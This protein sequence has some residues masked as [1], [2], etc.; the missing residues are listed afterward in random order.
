MG[1]ASNSG[2][3]IHLA[4]VHALYLLRELYGD[5]FIPEEVKVEVVE[6]GKSK[7][8]ADALMVEEAIR[9]GWIK[10]VA[11]E[12]LHRILEVARVAGV[13]DA[14]AKVIWYAYE[15]DLLVLL[16]DEPAREFARSLGLKVRGTLGV[17]LESV[18]RGILERRRALE[19]LD[20]VAQIMYLSADV[21]NAVKREIEGISENDA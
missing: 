13:H 2:P 19:L 6:R 8:F 7:G 21:C 20:D 10:V 14:E 17:L 11:V 12:V 16:D 15:N 1:A 18:R 4:K 9:E 5:I 3:L